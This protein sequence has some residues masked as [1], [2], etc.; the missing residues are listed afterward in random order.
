MFD[1]VVANIVAVGALIVLT[2]FGL[3]LVSTLAAPTPRGP[4]AR[5]HPHHAGPHPRPRPRPHPHP[6]QE[7]KVGGC[8]GTEFGCC[9]DGKTPRTNRHGTQ[10][11]PD[12]DATYPPAGHQ[13]LSQIPRPS[14]HPTMTHSHID[15]TTTLLLIEE[16]ATGQNTTG[17]V[18]EGFGQRKGSSIWE[19]LFNSSREGLTAKQREDAKG[20]D[21]SKTTALQKLTKS[22]LGDCCPTD[23]AG[24]A[25]NKSMFEA[26]AKLLEATAAKEVKDL[27]GQ[28]PHAINSNNYTVLQTGQKKVDDLLKL[29]TSAR[30]LASVGPGSA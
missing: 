16:T 6:Q 5:P 3:G 14:T 4:G 10:C 11:P 26:F 13:H 15:P 23:S 20:S 19:W 17:A 8:A 28:A 22:V 7:E 21:D 2:V 12:P 18:R 30:K 29:A 27:A 1:D 25:A 9:P 24:G